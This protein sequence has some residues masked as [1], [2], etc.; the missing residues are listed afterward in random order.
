MPAIILASS[1]ILFELHPAARA[2]YEWYM[3]Y[4]RWI[5]W[6][7]LPISMTTELSKE[8]LRGIMVTQPATT[9]GQ[10]LTRTFKL[11]APLRTVQLWTEKRPPDNTLLICYSAKEITQ[12]EIEHAAWLA[13]LSSLL[14]SV[15]PQK[16]SEIRDSL[17]A[18]MPIHMHREILQAKT[19]NDPMLSRWTGLSPS[20]LMHQRRQKRHLQQLEN[21]GAQNSLD[22]VI[23]A[24][25]KP[26]SPHD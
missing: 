4:P 23:G 7:D 14:D 1:S 21:A 13:V 15:N 8:P 5:N 22:D 18:H 12:K 9:Q 19:L 25:K 20:T 10:K 16:I 24:L 11:F 6:S 26:W 17:K 2:A 3:Q